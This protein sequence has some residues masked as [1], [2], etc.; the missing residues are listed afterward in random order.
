[1]QFQTLYFFL[2]DS[3][4]ILVASLIDKVLEDFVGNVFACVLGL[5]VLVIVSGCKLYCSIASPDSKLNT[6][7]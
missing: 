5:L 3:I 2:K 4:C 1:M 7:Y 6:F